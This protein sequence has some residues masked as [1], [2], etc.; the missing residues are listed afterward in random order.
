MSPGYQESVGA[1]AFGKKEVYVD[2]EWTELNL[3]KQAKLQP[4]G[5]QVTKGMATTCMVT[6][7]MVTNRP[8]YT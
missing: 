7:G 3:I 8:A 6:K 5:C 4:A 1:L 2:G